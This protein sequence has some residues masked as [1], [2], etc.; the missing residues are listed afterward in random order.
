MR[1]ARS[2]CVIEVS[3]RENKPQEPL[4]DIPSSSN[5]VFSANDSSVATADEGTSN[6]SSP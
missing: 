5:R 1:D 3:W 4:R 2:V 6:P